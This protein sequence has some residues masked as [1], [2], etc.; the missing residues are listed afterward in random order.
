MVGYIIFLLPL[1]LLVFFCVLVYFFIKT[2]YALQAFQQSAYNNGRYLRYIKENYK[3]SL[4][5]NELLPIL[6]LFINVSF[7]NVGFLLIKYLLVFFFLYYN[8]KFFNLS[9]KNY[10]QKIKLNITARVKRL[11]CSLIILMFVFFFLFGF[12]LMNLLLLNYFIYFLIM[13]ANLLNTPIEKF[14]RRGFKKKAMKKLESFSNLTVI[15]ITGSY[16]KTSI[17]NI[18]NDVLEDYQITLPTPSSFNTPMGL[19]ITINNDLNKMHENFIAEMGAYYKGEIKELALMVK[20]KIAVVSSI[21]PQHLETFKSIEN[22]QKTKMELVEYVDK[23]GVA[24]L[25]YDNKYIREYDIKNPVKTLF[26]S[27][28]KKD[29]DLFAD[30]II[31]LEDGMSFDIYFKNKKYTLKTKL[32][33]KH[34][35]Y[36]I[37]AAILVADY[38]GIDIDDIIKSISKLSK[39]EHRLELKKI[40]KELTIIDD[41]FNGNIEGLKE[42]VNILSKYNNTRVLITPGLIDG[43]EENYALNLEYAKSI[44]DIDH[45]IFIGNY[46]KKALNEGI[47]KC[48]DIQNFDNFIDGYDYAINNIKG[49]K[50]I[51]I[52]NDLPD[53]YN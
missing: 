14:I 6:L 35:I 50:T 42:G 39:I 34:N 11:I 29:V 3:Y 8:L 7:L 16:G 45:V 23:D 41:S 20:P 31:Y 22:I 25:N 47:N 43:G 30:N 27:L 5:V 38:N 44:K 13:L 9:K 51:L 19:S 4:G 24:I 28:E 37:L 53:K 26:Y 18:I 46:N 52:A 40:S 12:S 1:Y 49:S 36:N 33:G 21:G 2:K 32:L 17:K 15:G 48:I 10:T